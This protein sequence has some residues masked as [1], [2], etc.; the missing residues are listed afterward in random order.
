MVWF[1][2]AIVHIIWFGAAIVSYGLSLGGNSIGGHHMVWCGM[3]WNSMV[4]WLGNLMYGEVAG[5]KE[6]AAVLSS[7]HW[8]QKASPSSHSQL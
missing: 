3:V 8:L 4:G 6:S 1:W 2:V 7:R 5:G